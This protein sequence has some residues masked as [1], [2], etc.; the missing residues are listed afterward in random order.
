MNRP[1]SQAVERTIQQSA[2]QASEETDSFTDAVTARLRQRQHDRAVNY[3]GAKPEDNRSMIKKYLDTL[4]GNKPKDTSTTLPLNGAG[5]LRAALGGQA[6]T[7][8][9]NA[10][11]V[12]SAAGLIRDNLSGRYDHSG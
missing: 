3:Y 1:R 2:S 9:G 12:D 7:I 11:S 8:N 6:G 4:P 5:I 10:A